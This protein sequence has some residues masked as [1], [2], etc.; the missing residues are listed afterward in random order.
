MAI[1]I[2]ETIIIIAIPVSFSCTIP[3]SHWIIVM[4]RRMTPKAIMNSPTPIKTKLDFVESFTI[5]H[6]LYYY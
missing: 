4:D 5:N 6:I 3:A 1:N 2:I